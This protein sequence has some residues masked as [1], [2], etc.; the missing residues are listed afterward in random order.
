MYQAVCFGE[1]LWD[2]FKDGKKAGGA[3]MNV[4]LH[5]HKQGIKSYLIS[6]VGIDANGDE[7]LLFLEDNQLNTHFIQKHATLPTGIV[8]VELDKN[9]HASYTIVKPVSWDE[10]HFA[11]EFID[12]TKNADVLVFGSLA[13]RSE[14]SRNTLFK[15]LPLAKLKVFDMNLR[16]PHFHEEI[17]IS[18]LNACDILKINEVEIEYL[19]Q[20]FGL[21]HL[22]SDEQLREL[23][24]KTNTPVICVTLGGDGS[25]IFYKD[26]VIKHKGYKVELADTVGAGDAFLATF[27]G[28]YLKKLPIKQ[29]LDKASAAGAF[30]ASKHGANPQYNQTD[31][32]NIINQ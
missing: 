28:G 29:V 27:I 17:L 23:S 11:N 6:S 2:N 26:E 30:V 4:A 24:Q 21:S 16:P 5:L 25:I 3:P 14:I 13:C 18:L 31:L 1:I 15:L 8:E 19:T 10:I 7:L 22:T 9:L 32:E 12:I 20:L